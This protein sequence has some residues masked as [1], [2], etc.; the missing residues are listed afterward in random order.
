MRNVKPLW[1][2]LG[3]W[4]GIPLG[5]LDMHCNEKLG[6]SPF[7]TLKHG[8]ADHE[9]LTPIEFAE[10]IAYPKPDGIVSFDKLSSVFLS[11]TNHEEDQPIHLTLK[12]VSV[13]VLRNLPLYGEPARLYCP[14]GS[15][16]SSMAMRR[17]RAT[18][19]RHQRAELRPLQDLRHQGSVA[20]YRLGRA[21]RR[22]RPRLSEYVATF[23]RNLSHSKVAGASPLR[24]AGCLTGG[25]R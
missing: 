6:F 23:M 1:S 20:E 9:T 16:R 25:S 11:S 8:K 2:K 18:A 14:Q 10:P 13:P 22:G 24:R 7:G 3:T 12:D 17:R 21:R 4:L 15:M 5:A 19:L